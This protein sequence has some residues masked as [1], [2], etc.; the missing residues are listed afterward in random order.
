MSIPALT[1]WDCTGQYGATECAKSMILGLHRSARLHGRPY[2]PCEGMRADIWLPIL[3]ICISL[4]VPLAIFVGKN[5]LVAWIS[6]S[7]Q[8]RFNMEIEELRTEL[9]KNEEH[10]KSDLREKEAEISTLRNSVLSGSASRQAL[11]DRR[12]FEA[13]EKVWTN[14]NDLS[15]LK[16]F[17]AQMGVLNYKALARRA[18]EPSM[19]QVLE[20][21]GSVVPDIQQLKSVARDERPF[22]P[23]S[24]WAYFT[25]YRTILFGI[26]GRFMFLRTG[27]ENPEELLSKEVMQQILK[28]A[29]PIEANSS[30]NMNPSNMT[31]CWKKLRTT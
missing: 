6:N 24:A 29:L 22:L 13:V 9:R 27:V 11:L 17:A 21:I 16:A 8:H 20:T 28:A 10:F 4:G 31:F 23:E 1:A 12:R 2:Y 3:S 14:V 26:H 15:Q 7:V 30:M 25:A 18:R 19:Q 5:W